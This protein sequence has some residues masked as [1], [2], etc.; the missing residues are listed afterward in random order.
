MAEGTST[1]EPGAAFI[2]PQMAKAMASPLRSRVM[3][4]LSNG[5]QSPSEL[6]EVVGEDL[7][8]VA[9]ACRQLA[10]WGFAEVVDERKRNHRRGGK[11]KVYR[12][13]ER[14][15]F[16]TPNWAGLPQFLRNDF[17][18]NILKSLWVRVGDALGAGTFDA[19]VDRHLS[20]IGAALDRTAWNELAVRLD[21]L[22]SWVPEAEAESTVRMAASGE[23]P[24]PATIAL[25]AFRSPTL[26]EKQRRVQPT[27][28]R[29]VPPGFA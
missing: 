19:E 26:S 28:M 1:T 17:T 27:N 5:P 15:F 21:D 7:S 10:D 23:E 13:L 2:S 14:A 25:M 8:A 24:I 6:A 29:A 16:D 20:W 3:M 11:E 4:E 12:Q 22:L 9:R 18:V